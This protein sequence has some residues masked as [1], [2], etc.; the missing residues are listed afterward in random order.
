MASCPRHR[1]STW[2]SP[3]G[4]HPPCLTL[5]QRPPPL[6][7][8][9]KKTRLAVVL[10][11]LGG[12]DVPGFGKARSWS[13]CS[14]TRPSSVCRSSCAPSSRA[15]SPYA[16]TKPATANYE[17]LGGGSPLLAADQRASLVPSRPPCLISTCKMFRCDAVLAP[18]QPTTVAREVRDWAPGPDRAAPPLPAI[19]HHH[20]RIV[21]DRRGG[22]RRPRLAW[23]L[24]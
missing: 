23:S 7:T 21:P 3:V 8:S 10:F 6:S 2:Q 12:P 4:D 17:I 22:R 9:V 16:R 19:F 14:R 18:L 1:P 5:L 24:R 11:N 20:D 15:S 13:I